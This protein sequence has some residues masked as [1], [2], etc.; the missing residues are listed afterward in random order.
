[1]RASA[2]GSS[3]TSSPSAWPR[4]GRTRRWSSLAYWPTDVPPKTI[5]KFG[6]NVV[7]E[8]CVYSYENFER[9]RG[10]ADKFLVY[11]YNWGSYHEMAFGPK[12]TPGMIAR[13]VKF[14]HDRKVTR[15]VLLRDRRKLG[16]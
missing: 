9:W 15:H 11:L 8:L 6:P 14:F 4:T 16:A 5:A 7:I 3:T 10:K 1:M 2:I 13:Q 12:S